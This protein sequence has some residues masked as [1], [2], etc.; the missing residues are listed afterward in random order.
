MK[1]F[2]SPPLKEYRKYHK[3]KFPNGEFKNTELTYGTYGIK[4]MENKI[5]SAKSL[6]TFRKSISKLFKKKAFIFIPV[7][8]DI[9]V[10]KKPLEVRMGKGK[11]NVAYWAAK[12]GEGQIISEINFYGKINHEFAKSALLECG[13]KLPLKFKILSL[14]I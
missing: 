10:T 13:K 11:G 5:L 3:I 9:P 7:F 12:V 6:E 4:S 14:K 1:D 8:P 2:L